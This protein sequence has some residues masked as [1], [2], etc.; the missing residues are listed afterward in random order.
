PPKRRRIRK[1]RLLALLFVLGLLGIAAFGFGLLTAL[2][3][4]VPSLDITRQTQAQQ[5]NTYVYASDGSTILE[6]LRGSEARVVVPSDQISP[7]LKHAIVAVE[8]KRFY[9]HRGI[10]L[11][12]ILRA[13]V[14]DIRG[15]P[16]QGG[17]TI[18]QQFVK[19][20]INQSSRTLSRKFKE[21]AL[22]W[23]L[24]QRWSKDKILTAYLN[25]IYFGNGAYGV[26]QACRIY[27]G[28]GAADAN[29]AEAALLAGIPEDPTL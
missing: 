23:E 9:E 15:R 19:N 10:D 29:P 4:Q 12:G 8:D 5:R 25:T 18:T 28:H 16:V 17:S 21:A 2:A 3:A 1:L 22:A 7:W 14:N 20:S 27:F 6:I 24:E 13:A 26:E 11:R